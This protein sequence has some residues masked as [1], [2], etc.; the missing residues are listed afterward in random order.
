MLARITR[1][2]F[3]TLYVWALVINSITA[4]QYMQ[5]Q[6]MYVSRAKAFFDCKKLALR[7]QH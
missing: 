3:S 7:L 6:Y 1:R 2:A 5:P 4:V